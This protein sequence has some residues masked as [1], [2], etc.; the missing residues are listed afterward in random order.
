MCP[1]FWSVQHTV[2][3]ILQ[4]AFMSQRRTTWDS[5]L[6][7]YVGVCKV[8]QPTYSLTSLHLSHTFRHLFVHLFLSDPPPTASPFPRV[9]GCGE[10]PLSLMTVGLLPA[11][12]AAELRASAALLRDKGVRGRVEASQSDPLRQADQR[13][14]VQQCR[15]GV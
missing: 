2:I 9:P 12:A 13:S 3:Y 4:S 8:L 15:L 5:S 10:V 7:C 11:G 14:T 1:S 6:H